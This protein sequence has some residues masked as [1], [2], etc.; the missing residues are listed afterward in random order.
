[1]S[2]EHREIQYDPW[3]PSF[4]ADPY[5]RFKP[6]YNELPRV[7]QSDRLP[8]SVRA[9][10]PKG[11]PIV[12]VA[13]YADAVAVL[14]D[15]ARFGT[16]RPAARKSGQGLGVF[17]TPPLVFTDPPLHTRLRRLMGRP[18]S[19]RR[20]REMEPRIRVMAEELADRIARTARADGS[21]DLMTEFANP[22]PTM[23]IAEM[24]GVPAADY[25]D[26]KIWSDTIQETDF[27]PPG[28]SVPQRILNARDL[29]RAYFAEQIERHRRTPSD[30]LIGLLVS[31]EEGDALTSDEVL[32][33]VILLL[34]AGNETTAT[35]LGSGWL[36][37][38]RNPDQLEL[39]RNDRALI[40]GAIEE[41]LRYDPPL[42]ATVRHARKD[43][44]IAGTQVA[45]GTSV[46][47]LIGAANRDPAQF[48]R[49]EV[50]DITRDPNDHLALGEGI[51]FCLGAGLARLEGA[52]AIATLLERFPR[53][54][55][56]DPSA[57]AAYRSSYFIRCVQ[58]L[59]M[60][61]D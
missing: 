52:V 38:G 33:F 10:T 50:F 36:A 20:V 31:A 51:H 26:F 42:Q 41:M 60:T 11:A 34:M 25:E 57:P 39:L 21:F 53:L 13:R 9:T 28:A 59:P 37:L 18:F 16:Q 46:Y 4:I 14:R 23:V 17:G 3:D 58:S 40:P 6:M 35:M 22:L 12:M 43:T 32:S 49:P 24:L 27:V 47:V 61:I 55:L 45:E 5:S 29:M 56:L 1:M 7:V 44:E 48:E 30:D 54:R 15:D 19:P 2:I 8:R